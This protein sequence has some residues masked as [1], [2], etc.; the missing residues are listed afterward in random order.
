MPLESGEASWRPW[1]PR[2]DVGRRPRGHGRRGGQVV[3]QARAPGRSAP[4]PGSWRPRRAAALRRSQ[5]SGEAEGM[6]V[7]GE[8]AGALGAGRM[9]GA[10][11]GL[12]AGRSRHARRGRALRGRRARSSGELEGMG[13]VG[14]VVGLRSAPGCSARWTVGQVGQASSARPWAPRTAPK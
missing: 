12:V 9:L 6:G 13:V 4:A 2:A 10:G 5:E 11:A 1:A 8:V 14:E 3:G 7:V